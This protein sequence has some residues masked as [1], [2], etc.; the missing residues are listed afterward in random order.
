MAFR[1]FAT[2]AF[3]GLLAWSSPLLAQD[4]FSE[5]ESSALQ[6]ALDRGL[7][8]YQYDQ[9][10]WHGTN[11]LREDI[12][13]LGSSGIRGWV[14]NEVEAGFEVVF[15]S[16]SDM[17]YEAVWSGVYNGRDTNIGSRKR[18]KP[19]ERALTA[20][21]AAKAEASKLPRREEFQR[22]SGK[23]FN[24]VVMPTG[25]ADD[26]LY[27][28]YLV[29][30]STYESIPMGGHYRFEVRDGAIVASRKF[31]NSCLELPIGAADGKDAPAGLTISHS[32]D[33]VPTEIH[34]FSTFAANLLIYVVTTQNK[35]VWASEILNGQPR[36]R[37][38]DDGG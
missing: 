19:G 24:S 10:A 18:Y 28:Y 7:A 16:Q 34:V 30:Q 26:S 33:P 25:K 29:P 37:L 27:V 5:E 38:V 12:K 9:A 13:D 1:S 15:F 23:P 22:C 21:E 6:G 35:R 20:L 8:I 3:A 4:E 11:A 17:G 31:T 32:L 2:V 14:I 36:L